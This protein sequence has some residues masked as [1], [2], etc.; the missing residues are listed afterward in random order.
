MGLRELAHRKLALLDELRL[1]G[2]ANRADR[3][4]GRLAGTFRR[5]EADW[6]LVPEPGE[7]GR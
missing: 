7:F 4:G 1:E 2:R 5:R 6:G 3:F